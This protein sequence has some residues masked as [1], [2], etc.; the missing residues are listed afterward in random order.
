MNVLKHLSPDQR[1]VALVIALNIAIVII[2]STVGV[3]SGSL[4]LL[5]DAW[6][7]LSDVLA[8]VVTAI[9][10]GLGKRPASATMTYGYVR[11]EMMAT[12]INAGFLS[13]LMIW[14]AAE[15]L[16]RL[17]HPMPV[18]GWLTMITAAIALI[19]NSASAV[20]LGG[21]LHHPHHE[22]ETPHHDLNVRAAF[23]HMASDA[24]LSLAVVLGGGAMILW[25]V[26]WVDSSLSLLFAGV[27]L[28]ASGKLIAQSFAS[29]MD[30]SDPERIAGFSSIITAH[31]SVMEVHDLHLIHPAT[32][33]HYFSAHIVLD[34]N[35]QLKEIEMIIERLRHD[36]A[37][38]GATHILLQPETL[39]YRDNGHN[40]CNGHTEHHHGHT[41]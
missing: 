5:S 2:E 9:A 12:F 8:L 15:A 25:G 16:N 20:I 35:L 22:D 38:A 23:W 26:P 34:E 14:V 33:Q 37:H 31:P 11:S 7:N 1:R 17:I 21:H 19:V 29:L 3:I 32:H 40:H 28:M 24:L 10:L 6:H 39:K 18:D 4:A 13:L 30:K 36:L 41:E 27:I